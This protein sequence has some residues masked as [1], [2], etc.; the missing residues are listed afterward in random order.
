MDPTCIKSLGADFIK[1]S[2]AILLPIFVLKLEIERGGR[3]QE[4]R[5][6]KVKFQAKIQGKIMF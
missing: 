2:K 5:E 3:T 6:Q 1:V 4:Q